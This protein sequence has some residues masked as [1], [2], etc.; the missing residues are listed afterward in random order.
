MTVEEAPMKLQC[1]TCPCF[2]ENPATRDKAG[3]VQGGECRLHPPAV[4]VVQSTIQTVQ[5]SSSHI[6]TV[7]TPVP[8]SAMCWQHPVAKAMM[9]EIVGTIAKNRAKLR[10]TA[11]DGE[12]HE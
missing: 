12:L 9:D 8:I 3:I 2:A 10:E 7:F 5:G 4:V 6:Q 1:S 11:N